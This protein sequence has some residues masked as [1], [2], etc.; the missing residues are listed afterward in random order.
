MQHHGTW[1]RSIIA[2]VA[3]WKGLKKHDLHRSVHLHL[4]ATFLSYHVFWF[5][6]LELAYAF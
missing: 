6:L 3:N 1:G 4:V 2:G 5:L